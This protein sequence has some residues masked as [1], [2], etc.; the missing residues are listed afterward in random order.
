[1]NSRRETARGRARWR[2]NRTRDRALEDPRP[3]L[4][5]GLGRMFIT[6]NVVPT[7]YRGAVT[8]RSESSE[9]A[10]LRPP[11][12]PRRPARRPDRH[13]V[14]D[15][16]GDGVLALA[17]P[18]GPDR[19][20][21]HRRDA[22]VY[23]LVGSSEPAV[24]GS[25]V[26]DSAHDGGRP[27]TAGRSA[28]RSHYA[29]LAAAARLPGGWLRR[30]SAASCGSASSATCCRSRCSRATWP[31]SRVIMITSQLGKVTGV[32]VGRRHVRRG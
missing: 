28:I 8:S 19:P 4:V 20:D 7:S 24:G 5:S 9:A 26:H 10:A 22:V 25:R 2:R 1:M 13:G 31:A 32:D 11:R 6:A 30:S 17:G 27:G 15:P 16:A 23:A 29:A 12:P 3:V 21:R 18:A 14:P